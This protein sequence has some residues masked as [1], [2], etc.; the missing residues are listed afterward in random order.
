MN[1]KPNRVIGLD[2]FERDP[3]EEVKLNFIFEQVFKTPAGAEAL[4]YL[5]QISLESVAGG[6]VSNESLRHLEGQRYMVALIQSRVNK[7]KSQRIVKEKQDV[8]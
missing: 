4:R 3:S 8:R 7:G 2:N 1:T 5:K 6:E